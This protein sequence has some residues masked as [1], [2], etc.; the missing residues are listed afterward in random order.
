MNERVFIAPTLQW[1]VSPQTQVTLEA[2]YNHN[3]LTYDAG[4]VL[5]YDSVSR[6]FIALPRHQ[7][8][9]AGAPI[10]TDTRYLGLNWSHQF[11]EHWSIQQ[12]IVRHEVKSRYDPFYYVAGFTQMSPMSWTVDRARSFGDGRSTTTATVLDLTG[13]FDTGGLKHT[14]LVGADYYHWKTGIT[15]G[16][17]STVS[18][19]DAFNPAPPAG[20]SIDSTTVT[21]Y[22]SSTDNYGVYGQDQIALPG[23]VH[24]L[25]GMR[26]QKV[27]STSSN[28]DATGVTTPGDP[29]SDHAVT[30]RVGMLWQPRPW[31]SIYGN[32]AR[33]LRSEY[34]ERFFR[35][36][37]ASGKCTAVGGRHQGRVVRRQVESRTD[38][39][40]PDQT[41]RP[42]GRQG[43]RSN[44]CIRLPGGDR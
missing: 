9:A 25:G 43:S 1:R 11:N 42:Y 3:P 20:I 40:R 2:E 8:L 17:G 19:T 24:V 32:Y 44:R 21:T 38:L 26:Y 29:Q 13:H 12:Q 27:T 30:P 28:T 15:Y 34:R 35:E 41:E 14:L 31:L 33:E 5:P 22:G 23:H 39:V 4:Q 10:P 37:L 6:K 16:Y 36:T 7:N 18:T